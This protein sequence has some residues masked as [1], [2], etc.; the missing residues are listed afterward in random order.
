MA[1]RGPG[2]QL[3]LVLLAA[4]LALALALAWGESRAE[5][6]LRQHVDPSEPS[7]PDARRYCRRMMQRRDLATA[8]RCKHLNTFIHSSP[9]QIRPICGEGGEPAGGDLRVSKE[10]F[11]ITVCRL[12]GRAEPPDCDYSGASSTSRIVIAC[13]DGEPVHFEAQVESQA[14]ERGEL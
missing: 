5:K 1:L 2:L 4:G 12:R 13:A 11:P 7:P 9:G 8:S 14:G 6:F 10:P 3:P